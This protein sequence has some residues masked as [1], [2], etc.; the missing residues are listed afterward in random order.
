MLNRGKPGPICV[1]ECFECLRIFYPSKSKPQNIMKDS[2]VIQDTD[3]P[4]LIFNLS[5]CG[6]QLYLTVQTSKIIRYKPGFI[7]IKSQGVA[8]CHRVLQNFGPA[9]Y[10]DNGN[11]CTKLLLHSATLCDHIA[12][13][14][15]STLQ[16]VCAVN[17]C[18][19]RTM[20]KVT[21]NVILAVG[22]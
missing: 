14:L 16:S 15:S 1:P 18:D 22:M 5:F 17:N 2:L 21:F 6:L 19:A 12:E 13:T 10:C 4:R 7:S 8:K 20:N 9:T 3:Y 11:C